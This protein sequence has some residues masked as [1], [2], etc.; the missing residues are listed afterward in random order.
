MALSP[1]KYP[2]RVPISNN[3]NTIA[4]GSIRNEG[5][6]NIFHTPEGNQEHSVAFAA[7]QAKINTQNNL[8]KRHEEAH[9]SASGK[10]AVG[11]PVYNKISDKDGREIIVG[12]HQ[13][14]A[15]PSFTAKEHPVEH[16]NNVIAAAS[17]AVKGAEAPASFDELSGADKSV[18][19]KGREIISSAETAK[20]ERVSLQQKFG[21]SP[22]VK[23]SQDKMAEIK[24]KNHTNPA[25]KKNAQVG[26]SFNFMA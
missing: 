4:D 14:I 18:A 1:I 19:A 24:S 15:M 5:Q 9:R 21:I 25:V 8:V 3:K 13:M 26:Q 17:L 10:Q 2:I 16:I 12:G 20:T 23:L 6:H 11:S 7:Y 22:E